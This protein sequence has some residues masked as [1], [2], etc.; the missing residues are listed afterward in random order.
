VFLSGASCAGREATASNPRK[1]AA[2]EY[3]RRDLRSFKD[4]ALNVMLA[5]PL[6]VLLEMVGL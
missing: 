1:Q 3:V 4:Q 5:F 2:V 6:A